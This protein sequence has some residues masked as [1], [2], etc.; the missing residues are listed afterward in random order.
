MHFR[1]TR[2]LM[3][4]ARPKTNNDATKRLKPEDEIQEAPKGTKIGLL[5]KSEIMDAF[6]KL[7]QGKS[8]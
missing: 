3:L 7:A 2:Y 5:R 8:D 6:K 1:A 4:M